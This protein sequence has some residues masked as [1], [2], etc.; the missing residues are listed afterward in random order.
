MN[1]IT[2]EK[3]FNLNL[4]ALKEEEDLPFNQVERKSR[5]QG[6]PSRGVNS[7]AKEFGRRALCGGGMSRWSIPQQ[8]RRITEIPL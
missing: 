6:R 4:A 7:D 3:K 2:P 1:N 5:R 8:V